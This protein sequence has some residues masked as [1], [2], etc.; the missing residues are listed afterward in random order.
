MTCFLSFFN[1]KKIKTYFLSFTDYNL[2]YYK[3]PARNTRL[4]GYGVVYHSRFGSLFSLFRL[5]KTQ[6]PLLIIFL[7]SSSG[8]IRDVRMPITLTP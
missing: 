4:S 3:N 7:S 6:L 1:L 8:I 2:V 5:S